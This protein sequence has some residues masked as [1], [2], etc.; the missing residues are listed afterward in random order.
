MP[1]PKRSL[2]SRFTEEYLSPVVHSARAESIRQLPAKQPD[3][4]PP[5]Q[6]P[7]LSTIQTQTTSTVAGQTEAEPNVH[8]FRRHM[9]L[10]EPSMG[11]QQ[12]YPHPRLGRPTA[13]DV[14]TTTQPRLGEPQRRATTDFLLEAVEEA[15]PS[16]TAGEQAATSAENADSE[17]VYESD[18]VEDL[19]KTLS[20]GGADD[21][22][23]PRV[24]LDLDTEVAG[25]LGPAPVEPEDHPRVMLDLDNEMDGLVSS[26]QVQEE[27]AV[28]VSDPEQGEGSRPL[29][30][31]GDI[32]D[33]VFQRVATDVE[34]QVATATAAAVDDAVASLGQEADSH[35]KQDQLV[36]VDSTL[37]SLNTAVAAADSSRQS[38]AVDSAV[39][40]PTARVTHEHEEQTAGE[41]ET[42]VMSLTQHAG[43]ADEADQAAAINTVVASLRTQSAEHYER[44]DSLTLTAALE[45]V[46]SEAV[47]HFQTKA[48]A[49]VDEALGDLMGNAQGAFDAEQ[50]AAV[51]ETLY[52]VPLLP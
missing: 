40:N 36:A 44:S 49:T 10:R 6:Q 16:S 48:L 14:I 23:G 46:Q 30:A 7:L 42:V 38:E 3:Q 5:A 12:M 1:E 20:S 47:G 35:F 29:N 24:M 21:Y 26:A 32:A 19:M 4:A 13:D 25:L 8:G 37:Q 15:E 18:F 22:E 34:Q 50:A 39:T 41:V 17:E 52:W 11:V 27:A 31:A 51:G 33:D 9:S 28:C 43:A 2:R 45:C